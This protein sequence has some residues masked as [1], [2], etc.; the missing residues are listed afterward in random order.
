MIST[1][2]KELRKERKWTIKKASEKIGV[3]TTLLFYLETNRHKPT[4]ETIIKLCKC[5]SITSDWLL[6][7][8]KSKEH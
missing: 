2:L 5:Y 4:V 7:I 6:E 8:K 1:K 3:S